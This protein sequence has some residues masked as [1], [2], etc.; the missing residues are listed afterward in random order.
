[1]ITNFII[2]LLLFRKLIFYLERCY[3]R[4]GLEESFQFKVV[5]ADYSFYIDTNRTEKVIFN[6]KTTNDCKF[7]G[8]I[9]IYEYYSDPNI[10]SSLKV[11]SS[12]GKL[13][14]NICEYCYVYN[15]YRFLYGS[16]VDFRTMITDWSNN[17]TTISI[18]MDLVYGEDDLSIEKPFESFLQSGKS[19]FLYLKFFEAVK[20]NFTMH[21]IT[22]IP[23]ININIH[24][25]EDNPRNSRRINVFKTPISSKVAYGQ[26]I[27]WLIYSAKSY[28]TIYIAL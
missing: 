17:K 27:S 20:I 13:I 21:N 23:F 7:V 14:N 24:E 4:D 10:H 6:A 28:L 18:R 8:Q 12:G 19:Y 26:G 15:V 25:F 11:V 2:L 3:I 22:G 16:Y 1:M 5:S 9:Y